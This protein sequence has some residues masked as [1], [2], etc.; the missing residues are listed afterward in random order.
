MSVDQASRAHHD[1][2]TTGHLNRLVQTQQIPE[3]LEPLG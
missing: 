2:L 1:T 3:N